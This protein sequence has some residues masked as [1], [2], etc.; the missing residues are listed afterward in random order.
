MK[1]SLIANAIFNLFYTLSSVIF[2]V[3]IMAYISRIL[4]PDGIGVI[5]YAQNLSYYFVILSTVG[6]SYYGIKQ[7]A[8]VKD[9]TEETNRVFSEIFLLSVIFSVFSSIL[10]IVLIAS[11]SSL[12]NEFTLYLMY[13][14]QIFLGFTNIDWFYKGK[15]DFV[16]ITVRSFILR[17]ITLV[18]IF[19]MVKTKDDYLVF[20]FLMS[21]GM[22]SNHIVN[23]FYLKKYI[24]F[25]IKGLN[26]KRHVNIVF[27][28]SLLGLLSCI[29]NNIDI[30]ILGFFGTNHDIGIYSNS[31]KLINSLV[32]ICTAISAVLLPRLSYVFK[33][34]RKQL[35]DILDNAFSV[36]CFIVFPA[37]ILLIV[38]SNSI[39]D[40][41][42]GV[43]FYEVATLVKFLSV[44]VFIKVFGDLFCFQLLIASNNEKKRLPIN[45]WG[46]IINIILNIVLIPFFSYYGSILALLITELLVNI[47]LFVIVYK[48]VRFKIN[49]FFPLSIGILGSV[50]L[51]ITSLFLESYDVSIFFNTIFSIS[52]YVIFNFLVKNPIIDKFLDIFHKKYRIF[53]FKR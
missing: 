12:K 48:K 34:D 3:A 50:I 7:I 45:L 51:C 22:I 37:V 26:I 16:Y 36:I 35:N 10:Y 38:L 29:Y 6:F 52:V 19:T 9:D 15:E 5:S 20:A 33:H 11:V 43:D 14:I 28:W 49:Y 17:I 30:T 8:K 2:P 21:F 24:K 23:I 1:T 32:S 39:V 31:I 46:V 44:I 27:Y 25:V 18:F 47:Y 13:G 41:F 4:L 53:F 40:I 42:F